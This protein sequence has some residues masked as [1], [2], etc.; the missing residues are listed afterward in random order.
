MPPEYP[1]QPNWKAFYHVLIPKKTADLSWR[2][3]HWVL[4]TNKL[5]HVFSSEIPDQCPFCGTLE[6]LS[7]AYVECARLI[8]LFG[9]LCE[10]C[11]KLSLK[12][13]LKV[14]IFG[15]ESKTHPL[16]VILANFLIA[17]AKKSIYR[18][19]KAKIENISGCADN[20]LA[21]FKGIVFARIKMEFSFYTFINKMCIFKSMW[22]LNDALCTV[23][24]GLLITD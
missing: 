21:L 1:F 8:P 24:N 20:L 10:L 11:S 2:L 23:Q 6:T 22:A 3:A 4:P 12:F 7:H 16:E 17:T 14:F 18:T 19:R 5:L 13:T 15:F 9:L